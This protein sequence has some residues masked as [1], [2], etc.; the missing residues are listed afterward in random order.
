MGVRITI[1]GITPEGGAK[2]TAPT[3]A[4]SPTAPSILPFALFPNVL[5][6]SQ[7]EIPEPQRC[8]L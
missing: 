7:S 8:L 2:E 5:F 3:I 4:T 6:L 1:P